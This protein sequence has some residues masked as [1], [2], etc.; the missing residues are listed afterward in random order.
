MARGPFRPVAAQRGRRVVRSGRGRGGGE[1]HRPVP[2]GRSGPPPAGGRRPG[3][4][5]SRRRRAGLRLPGHRA[6]PARPPCAACPGAE[7]GLGRRQRVHERDRCGTRLAE[8]GHLGPAAGRLRAGLGRRHRPAGTP[9]A[10]PPAPAGTSPRPRSEPPGPVG[11]QPGRRQPQRGPVLGRQPRPGCRPGRRPQ[12]PG[13]RR[14]PGLGQREI[15]RTLDSARN[16]GRTPA[17]DYQAEAGDQ[18]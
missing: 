3:G 9:S 4:R 6:G 10:A 12:P 11:R 2:D 8:P 17:P 14:P 5:D 16:S 18:A 1:L 13:R 15:T 7:P